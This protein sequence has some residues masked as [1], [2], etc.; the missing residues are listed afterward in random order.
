MVGA[1][2]LRL[3]GGML[4]DWGIH[5][6]DQLLQLFPVNKVY[7]VY[8][9]TLSILTPSVDDYF[10]L[11]LTFDNNTCAT[12]L[13]T[14]FSL[15]DRPRWF[16]YGD[17]GTLKLDDFSGKSGGAAKIRSDVAGFE[18]VFYKAPIGPSRTMS[19]LQ[20]EFIEAIPLPVIE[21]T[22][23]SSEY[24]RNL[25]EAVKGNEQQHVTYRDMQRAMAII[26]SAFDSAKTNAVIKVNI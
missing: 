4:Y 2:H 10:E 17:R 16:V 20:P 19:P 12:V 5:L 14:T 22:E 24:H 18:S 25:A 3:G 15:Q 11:K 6:I 9:R 23:N 1:Q 21:E 13:V 8:C 7:Y 26:D